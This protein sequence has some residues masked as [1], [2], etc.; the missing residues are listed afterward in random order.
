MVKSPFQ[1]LS[2][3]VTHE[4]MP[5]KGKGEEEDDDFG[6]GAKARAAK[7]AAAAEKAS[8]KAA[9]KE[10]ADSAAW[11]DGADTRAMKRAAER[12][13]EAA[14]REAKKKEKEDLLKREEAE[15]AH[16]KL[17]GADKV[18]ARKAAKV[19]EDTHL[20]THREAPT[21]AA[22]GIDGAIAVMEV[23]TAKGGA[24]GM[25][26]DE[27]ASGGAGG[28]PTLRRSSSSE[29]HAEDEARASRIAAAVAAGA[30]AT[31]REDDRNPEKRMAAAWARFKE[32]ELPLLKAEYPSLRMSQHLE[33]LQ[34]KWKRSP[35]NPVNAAKT[36]LASPGSRDW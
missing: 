21:L 15:L 29:E 22:S 27:A 20:H 7:A 9:E 4:K 33:M 25:A 2:A 28:P 35:E 30:T 14:E 34:R 36:P 13:R 3:A 26:L 6:P 10:A 17:R 8:K 32:R 31:L 16:A 12:E 24:A 23:A 11:M 1:S 19:A 18:A 5:R